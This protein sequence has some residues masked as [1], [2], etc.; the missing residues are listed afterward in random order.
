[1]TSITLTSLLQILFAAVAAFAAALVYHTQWKSALFAALG[2]GF[3]WAIYLS[4]RYVGW[5]VFLSTF[6]A[7]AFIGIYG[8][9]LAR[10]LKQPTTVIFLPACIPLL[11]GKDL[12]YMLETIITGDRAACKEHGM[13]L[14]LYALGISLGLAAI[15]ELAFIL[16]SIKKKASQR[17]A[18]SPR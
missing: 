11:P 2:G 10:I 6:C 15:L 14:L 4:A 9:I 3:A 7:S 17:K 5:G 12:Y 18:G 16:R 13:L 1:M 8:E